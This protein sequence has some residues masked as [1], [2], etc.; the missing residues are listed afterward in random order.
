[1]SLRNGGSAGPAA[2][3]ARVVDDD[4]DDDPSM[5]EAELALINE[6]ESEMA[7]QDAPSVPG[8]W[9]GDNRE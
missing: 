6:L 1:M 7:E 2:K 9:L 4:F 5:F 3:K 8:E